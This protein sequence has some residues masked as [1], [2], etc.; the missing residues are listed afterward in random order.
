MQNKKGNIII[1][2]VCIVLA[3][4]ITLVYL[5]K[6]TTSR[7]YTTKKIGMTLYAREL[8]NTLARLSIQ[9]LNQQLLN[10]T[11]ETACVHAE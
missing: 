1:I 7:I 3:L 2:V 9:Y 8:A 10:K 6:N 5:L 4:M 11:D